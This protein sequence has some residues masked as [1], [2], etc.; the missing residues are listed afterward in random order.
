MCNRQCCFEGCKA[1]AKML[2]LMNFTNDIFLTNSQQCWEKKTWN[3]K[4]YTVKSVV[5]Q[6]RRIKKCTVNLLGHWQKKQK[7]S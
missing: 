7:Q 5:L 3:M 1:T 4:H 2:D 6:Q